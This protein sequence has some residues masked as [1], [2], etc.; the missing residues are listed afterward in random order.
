MSPRRLLPLGL[1]AAALAA[2][3]AGAHAASP[4]RWG[5][6]AGDVTAGSAVLWTKVA[7]PG[8]VGVT[9]ATDRRL[10]RGVAR[11][12]SLR[13]RTAGDDTVRLDVRRL[14]PG[15]RYF[16]AFR[17]RGRRSTI[18]TF[19]TAPARRSTRTIRFGWTG[20]QDATPRPGET[21]PYWNDLGV[22]ARMARAG[23][24]FN[25]ELGDTIYSDSEVPGVEGKQ[26]ALTVPQKWEKYRLI[27]RLPNAQRFMRATGTYWQWDDHEFL[28]DFSP[29]ESSFTAS[30]GTAVNIDGRTLY[31]R[32][33][34]AFR[35][36][37]P[38]RYSSRRGLYRSFRW[39]RN[40]QVF[41]LDERSF[42]SAKASAAC[43]NP[44]TGQPDLAPTAPQALR[45]AFA[46]IVPSL[47]QPV[48]QSCLDT[49]R[50]PAR[51]MLGARQWAAFER[52]IKRSTATWKVVMT[53]MEA[54]QYYTLPYDRWEG[55]EADRQRLLE[56]LRSIPNTVLLATDVHANLGV[57]ARLKTLEQ[58]GPVDSGVFEMSTG[59]VATKS[60]NLEISDAVGNPAAGDLVV[61]AFLTPPPPAGI[62]MQCA[63]T[64]VFSYG[65]VT[66]T[67]K[68]LT[69][70]PRDAAGQPVQEDDGTPCGPF[71][72][73]AR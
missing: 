5:V 58:G 37:S 21:E 64:K 30:G 10:R 23:N 52:D 40:L 57:D 33:A 27:R 65:Q 66:V 25:I 56:L 18:G 36:Y 46:A 48:S 67:S 55:Y 7:R 13:A 14:R 31:R 39:G 26:Q 22:L 73:T 2:V 47:A 54:K 49:I 68:R 53:E 24:D 16:Y 1:A 4:F 72:L 50:D 59:P 62:G 29:Q 70:Q 12:A 43:R 51:T 6:A 32:G 15:T 35:D 41:L 34:K 20:D 8:R 38:V 28:N 71:E 3:P 17:T 69:I 61:G 60:F 44:Q 9:I 19:R 11:R 45:T 42:R 63:A